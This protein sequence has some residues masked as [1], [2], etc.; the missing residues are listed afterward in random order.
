MTDIKKQLLKNACS[1]WLAQL[2]AAIVGFVMLPYN[3]KHLGKE[4]YAI[5][6][7]AV[8]AIAMMQF[9]NLGMGPALLRFFAQA[10]TRK[11]QRE[12]KVLS[13]TAQLILG[14]LGL[15]GALVIVAAIPWFHRFYEVPVEFRRGAGILLLCMAGSFF[16]EFHGMVFQSIV[17]AN[18]RYD[19]V[20]IQKITSSWLRFL[21]LVIF[22]N[23]FTPSLAFLGLAL[24]LGGVYNYVALIAMSLR[25]SGSAVFF[26][27]SCVRLARL[28]ELFSFSVLTMIQSVFFSASIQVPFL[29]LGKTLGKES[30]TLFTPAMLIAT[31]LSVFLWQI[32]SPLTPL[33]ARD[34]VQTGGDNIGRWALSFGQI[35]ACAGYGCIFA[36]IAFMPDILRIWLGNDFVAV[37]VVVT[38]VAVGNVY[39]SI[40]SVNYSLALGSSTIAP[41]AYSS[42]VMAFLTSLGTLLGTLWWNWGLWEIAICMTVVRVLRNTFFLSWVYSRLFKYSFRRYFFR[43]YIQPA[44]GG[45]V[46]LAVVLTVKRQFPN[47]S[48][49]FMLLGLET[50]VVGMVYAMITWSFGLNRETRSMLLKR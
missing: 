10:I 37:A 25:E 38:V 8:S 35:V 30:A 12:I 19:L 2:S 11:D 46:L 13:S 5:N 31:Y 17:L 28:P 4:L 36:S 3:L 26:S 47:F 9:L 50:V 34:R 22:Y 7:L 40:Q 1:G 39:S 33:A 43:V 16:M 24:L 45:I 18:N 6:V 42:V 44:I 21:L 27:F 41:V 32:A 15:V 20:N 49:G 29:I 14:T 23:V 48:P